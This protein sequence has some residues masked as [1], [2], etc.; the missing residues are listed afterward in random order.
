MDAMRLSPAGLLNMGN[1]CYFNAAMQLLAR[2]FHPKSFMHAGLAQAVQAQPTNKLLAAILNFVAHIWIDNTLHTFQSLGLTLQQEI[3]I[4]CAKRKISAFMTGGGAATQEDATEMLFQLLDGMEFEETFQGPATISHTT[5]AKWKDSPAPQRT[6]FD[7]IFT[8]ITLIREQ[9]AREVAGVVK[10]HMST[11]TATVAYCDG[12]GQ[13]A[14]LAP[15]IQY[16]L[17]LS[18]CREQSDVVPPMLKDPC[19]ATLFAGKD[20]AQWRCILHNPPLTLHAPDKKVEFV[21][22]PSRNIVI[23]DPSDVHFTCQ[24]KTSPPTSDVEWGGVIFNEFSGTDDVTRMLMGCWM[25]ENVENSDH[26][27]LCPDAQCT[28]GCTV[29]R[30]IATRDSFPRIMLLTIPRFDSHNAKLDTLVSFPVGKRNGGSDLVLSFRTEQPK[31]YSPIAILLHTGPTSHCGHYTALIHCP[32][33]NQWHHCDDT[34]VSLTPAISYVAT[35]QHVQKNV[36][37][38]V[39]EEVDV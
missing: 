29:R 26:S 31:A 22:H 16:G 15:M 34:S 38:L 39:Y 36:Y 9:Y 33:T 10:K 13:I 20:V 3:V 18:G 27:D 25:A 17:M 11:V 21:A 12:C 14:N 32:D 4:Q 23:A 19:S 2:I 5:D 30:M 24:F 8:F 7:A 35:Q 28:N 37:M 6:K 1:T